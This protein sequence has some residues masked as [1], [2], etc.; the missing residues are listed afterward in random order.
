MDTAKRNTLNGRLRLAAIITLW[1]FAGSGWAYSLGVNTQ[2]LG[3]VEQSVSH[4]EREIEAIKDGNTVRTAELARLAQA[5]ESL[6][7]S[8]RELRQDLRRMPQ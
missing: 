5:I 7:Q 6:N 8:V 1:V 4:C 2:R 3:G